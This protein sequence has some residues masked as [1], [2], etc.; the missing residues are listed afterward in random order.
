MAESPSLVIPGTR[1]QPYQCRNTNKRV[2]RTYVLQ[3]KNWKRNVVAFLIYQLLKHQKKDTSHCN[4]EA[5]IYI[6]KKNPC[7][8][9]KKSPKENT[10]KAWT[11]TQ[12]TLV[13]IGIGK[14]LLEDKWLPGWGTKP[15]HL[16]EKKNA[17][18][19]PGH[20]SSSSFQS[21]HC[22]FRSGTRRR[23]EGSQA[24]KNEVWRKKNLCGP[25]CWW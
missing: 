21:W 10:W 22:P 24:G 11:S 9:N 15:M 2:T 1:C 6:N 14:D 17:V 7:R 18:H 3:K 23:L 19:G 13:L 16:H 12:M 8:I 25:Y 5:Y 20:I 4:M